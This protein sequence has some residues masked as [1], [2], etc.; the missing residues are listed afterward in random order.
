MPFPLQLL[1]A[2]HSRSS[3]PHLQFPLL[4]YVCNLT[5]VLAEFFLFNAIFLLLFQ[6]FALNVYKYRI[7]SGARG[8]S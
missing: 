4:R 1:L 7:F 2:L 6:Y 3:R 5:L 8:E